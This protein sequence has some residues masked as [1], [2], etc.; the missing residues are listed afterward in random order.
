MRRRIS[1]YLYSDNPAEAV[2][3]DRYNEIFRDHSQR[4]AA[5][6]IRSA[7]MRAITEIDINNI[8]HS[9]NFPVPSYAQPEPVVERHYAE[10][11]YQY[12]EPEPPE[13]QSVP[14]MPGLVDLGPEPEQPRLVIDAQAGKRISSL[15][16]VIASAPGVPPPIVE[17]VR[18][19]GLPGIEILKS[20]DEEVDPNPELPGQHIPIM[21]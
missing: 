2:V 17:P 3:I 9:E 6:L 12:P 8:D 11:D 7:I 15:K 16:R 21:W 13:M 10:T 5:S 14:P 18:K 20:D 19:N 1:T 4:V